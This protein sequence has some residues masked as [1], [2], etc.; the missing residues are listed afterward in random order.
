MEQA[1]NFV[2]YVGGWGLGGGAIGLLV[3]AALN[4]IFGST[5]DETLPRII[6]SIGIL[7]GI[8]FGSVQVFGK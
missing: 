2:L 5:N 3:G 6:G 7:I 1:W 8:V 4:G